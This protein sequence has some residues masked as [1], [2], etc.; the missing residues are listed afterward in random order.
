MPLD[1]AELTRRMQEGTPFMK[2]LDIHVRRADGVEAE[3]DMALK[4]EFRQFSGFGHGGV[5]ATLADI[6]CTVCHK[7]PTVTVDLHMNYLK[8]AVGDRLSAVGRTVREG[9]SI[10]T[11]TAEVFAHDGEAR[12]LVAIATATMAPAGGPS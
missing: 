12:T 6:A 9:R 8:P 7:T 3:V 1:P 11:T 2:L 4:P 5:V 10:V